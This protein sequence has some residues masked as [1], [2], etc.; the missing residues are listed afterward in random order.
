MST[1]KLEETN[2]RAEPAN[3]PIVEQARFVMERLKKTHNE[4]RLGKRTP[5]T[6]SKILPLRYHVSAK[7]S[8]VE[9]RH[10]LARTECCESEAALA[11]DVENSAASIEMK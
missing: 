8:N 10:L 6:P 1:L 7:T 11:T 4:T 9:Q 2:G 5:E 3:T